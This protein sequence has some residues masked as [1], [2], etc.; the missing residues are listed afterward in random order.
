MSRTRQDVVAWMVGIGLL[1]GLSA[2]AVGEETS[3][4]DAPLD[5]VVSEVVEILNAGVSDSLILQW[6]DS[7]DR[8]PTDVGSQGLIALTEAGASEQLTTTLL[9]LVGSQ[10]VKGPLEKSKPAPESTETGTATSSLSTAV[11]PG[12]PVGAVEAVVR[13]GAKRVWVD[14]D[15][16]DSPREPRWNV[17]LY[18]DGDLVAWTRP[19]LQGEP[20]EARRV[21]QSG[22]REMR[23]V[24]QRNEELRRGW[25][26]ESLVVPTP[27]A[28]PAQAGDPIEIEVDLRRIW[29]LWRDRKDGGPMSWVVRQ[30]DQVLSESGGSGGNPDRWQPVC[31]DV[32]ANFPDAEGVP[33]RFR[34]AMSR[35]IRWE[36]LWTGAGKSTSRADILEQLA[37]YD[38]EPLV[39]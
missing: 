14:E 30:G 20:A 27:I 39:R 7:T 1:L 8:R 31:E 25:S 3:P 15:E 38:F 37:E 23:V 18:L 21:V 29:G 12:A 10:D 32:E 16:P 19:T 5:P 26:Y 17:Y 4:S 36:T 33:K 22:L 2:G 11:S 6:L 13:L 28:Y 9:E 34:S 24:L 35:C